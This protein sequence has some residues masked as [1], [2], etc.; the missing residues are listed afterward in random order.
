MVIALA[1][2]A[3]AT[4]GASQD[5]AGDCPSGEPEPVLDA[6]SPRIHSHV[7]RS[8]A[9]VLAEESAVLEPD[10]TVHVSRA[11]AHT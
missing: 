1:A 3:T 7:F 4:P 2:W 10:L 9:H 8:Q 5:Q 11:D 6:A